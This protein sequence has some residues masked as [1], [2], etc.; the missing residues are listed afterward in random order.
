MKQGWDVIQKMS[1][2]KCE[3]EEAEAAE[4]ACP[5]LV[6]RIRYVASKA[7]DKGDFDGDGEGYIDGYTDGLVEGLIENV[8]KA[9]FSRLFYML[10]QRRS[11]K[12]ISAATGIPIEKVVSAGKKMSNMDL[13][14]DLD[15]F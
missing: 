11:A 1:A 2:D 6:F 12:E 9:T 5:D 15:F 13:D 8:E 4:E 10:G 3:R 14:L 7:R